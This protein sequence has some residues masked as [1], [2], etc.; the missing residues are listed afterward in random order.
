MH[1][2]LLPNPQPSLA[3]GKAPL[4]PSLLLLPLSPFGAFLTRYAPPPSLGVLSALIPAT[5]YARLS[6][7]KSRSLVRFRAV[8]APS[9]GVVVLLEVGE[10][11][12]TVV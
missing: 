3:H 5:R 9:R 10:D 6:T 2:L 4:F 8:M 12:L 7:A 1:T 11:S